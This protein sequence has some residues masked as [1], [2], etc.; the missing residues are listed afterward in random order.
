MYKKYCRNL[1][2]LNKVKEEVEKE[3]DQEGCIEDEEEFV[4][5]LDEQHKKQFSSRSS[6][7]NG[8]MD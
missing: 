1:G 4:D 3:I 7:Y 5:E 6:L 8:S 2:F